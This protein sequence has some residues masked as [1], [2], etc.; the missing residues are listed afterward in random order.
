MACPVGRYCKNGTLNATL[1]PEGTLRKFPGAR[2]V[3]DCA[4]C[5]PGKYC[6]TP[7]L[8]VATGDCYRGY[9][10]PAFAK[11][12]LEKPGAY[13]CPR[14]F[15]CD[16]GTSVPRGCPPGAY[17]TADG[18]WYCIPCPAGR[19]CPG[20]T[21]DPLLCPAHH[22]CPNN[23]IAPPTCPNGTYTKISLT[24]LAANDS[25]NPCPKG[26]YCQNGVLAGNCSGG[27]LCL[28][29]STIPTPTDTK[30]GIICPIGYYCP[31]GALEKQKCPKGLV[32]GK[33]GSSSIKDCQRCPAGFICTVDSTV[34]QPCERGYYCPYNMT[35][36]PCR[37]GTY[38]NDTKA[39]DESFCM[40]CPA[41]Y[42]CKGE[43]MLIVLSM[44]STVSYI[45]LNCPTFGL[46]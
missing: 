36:Q 14:G 32:I 8:S 46:F 33:E 18:S 38:N 25:C 3:N 5:D 29:G 1:C 10:C 20:N 7:G 41:G 6:A 17:Q 45:V 27:Y 21:S 13:A 31:E 2:F 9:Y 15:Y 30:Q 23:T 16:Y 35:R 34:P 28:T 19:F 43:G 40:S 22:Y 37:G 44:V 12:K 26:V 42:W 4:P 11:I 24:G 39:S